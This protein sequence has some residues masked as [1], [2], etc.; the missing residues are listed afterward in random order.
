MQFTLTDYQTDAVERIIKRIKSSQSAY[1]EQEYSAVVLSAAT[2][3]GKTVIATAVIEQLI[4]GGDLVDEP[5][6]D[7]T[8]LW[9]TTDPALNA[10]TLEKM[11]LSSSQLRGLGRFRTITAG[12]GINQEAFDPGTIT[13]LNTQAANKNAIISKKTDEQR[14][15]IWDTIENTVRRFGANFIV[16]ID[17]AHRGVEQKSDRDSATI[18]NKIVNGTAPVA[19][20][21]GISATAG[22]FQKAIETAIKGEARTARSVAVSIADVQRSGIIKD[23]IVLHNPA[24][25][26]IGTL[27]ADTTLIRAGVQKLREFETAWAE[28]CQVE[29]EA[30]VIP[31]MVIQVQDLPTDDELREIVDA[32]LSEWPGLTVRA[33]VN[34]FAEH[35]MIDL[36]NGRI[37]TYM[38]PHH[39]QDASD[40]RIVLAKNA[41]TTGWDCPRA[42]VLVSLRTAHDHTYIAQLIGRTI[43]QPLARRIE[44]N[45][46][47]NKVACYLPRF[48]SDG[49]AAVVNQ[50]K[51]DG[52]NGIPVEI[53]RG[54]VSYE[55]GPSTEDAFEVLSALPSYKIPSKIITPGVKRL[56][57]LAAALAGD[58]IYLEGPAEVRRLINIQLDAIAAQLSDRLTS[59]K[60]DIEAVK[61]EHVEITFSG[62]MLTGEAR[63]L[64]LKRDSNNIDD[65]FRKASRTLKDGVAE[66]YWQY[67]VLKVPG[68]IIGH[69]VTVAALGTI[70]EATTSLDTYA[71]ALTATWL[72]THGKNISQ[73]SEGRRS[74]YDVIRGEAKTPELTTVVIPS[75]VEEAVSAPG[76]KAT[77]EA[78][79]LAYVRADD[80]NRLPNH[81]FVDGKDSKYY[82]SALN[83]LER[84]VLKVEAADGA[85]WY[86]NPASGPRSLTIPY[87]VTTGVWAGLHPDFLVFHRDD[88][89]SL[90]VSIVDPHGSH[91]D[92]AIPKLKGL[93]TYASVHGGSYRSILAIDRIDDEMLAVPVHDLKVSDRVLSMISNGK[94][95][96]EIIRA[97]G[98]PL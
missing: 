93:A 32:V 89:G 94:T 77:D 33:F 74:D 72:K 34:T 24:A 75:T 37:V 38:Q 29:G 65:V 4:E 41:I 35:Q 56:H 28:Y 42:E 2:G 6:P 23:R 40:V 11:E 17:E 15:T 18:I 82:V 48:D 12:H 50:F 51:E 27:E 47:L 64:K 85:P 67:L 5:H 92:D 16:F 95:A 43:R 55:R 78:A 30:R 26:T 98:V 62:E 71:H 53:V 25:S 84:E 10:Q 44:S 49:V 52:E 69:K 31:A 86:R 20:I 9:V 36:G 63:S 13:F 3:A 61:L 57:R 45:E 8:I 97:E 22:K 60:A 59:R 39:I 83:D 7:T 80:P 68:D 58:D 14:Y 54:T 19:V 66:D 73:L 96:K 90:S 46:A 91:F 87:E 76:D 1:D 81:L 88:E 70:L 21:V 79:V